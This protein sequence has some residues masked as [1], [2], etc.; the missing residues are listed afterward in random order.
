MN[1]KSASNVGEK[2]SAEIRRNNY[3]RVVREARIVSVILADLTFNVDPEAYAA[4]DKK[5]R[6]YNSS[7]VHFFYDSEKGVFL[8]GVRWI[9]KT[10]VGRKTL[11]NCSAV[12]N[13]VYDSISDVDEDVVRVFADSVGRATV[14]GY[15]RG[16]FA[17]LDWS[18]NLRTPPLP[19]VRFNPKV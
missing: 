12:Y 14:Y 16:L 13:V 7:I 9:V 8:A 4:S 17:H 2:S 5:K 3:N 18:A 6:S 10:K 11:V 15:F 19:V 1:Q